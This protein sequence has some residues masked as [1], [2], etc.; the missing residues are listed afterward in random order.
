MKVAIGS[1]AGRTTAGTQN[2]TDASVT[3]DLVAAFFIGSNATA[4]GTTTAGA[5]ATFGCTDGTRNINYGYGSQDNTALASIVTGMVGS[6]TACLQRCGANGNFTV[7]ASLSAV[8]SNG[9]T[10]NYTTVDGVAYKFDYMLISGTDLEIQ[11]SS[12][13]FATTDTSKVVTHNCAAAPDAIMYFVC[14]GSTGTDS[15]FGAL[16][17]VMGMFDGTNAAG[18]GPCTV[19]GATTYQVSQHQAADGGHYVNGFDGGASDVAT[20]SVSAV[21]ATTFTLNRTASNS[22][23]AFVVCVSFRHKSGNAAFNAFQTT[24]PTATGNTTLLTGMAVKPQVLFTF[25]TRLTSTA[26]TGDSDLAGGFGFGMSCNNNGTTQQGAVATSIQNNVSTS[27]CKSYE[28]PSFGL[29]GLDHVGTLQR[30]AV[31]NSWDSGGVTLNWSAV[32]A[33]AEEVTG[34]AFGLLASAAAV[35]TPYTQTQFFVTETVN[36]Q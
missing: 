27:V 7:Q 30:S 32:D 1:F 33:S 22:Q 10:L 3:S 11:C 16:R 12:T 24:M 13:Q 23:A 34:L 4:D 25:P 2:V 5:T 20:F 36:Q 9:L 28:S 19:K 21:G 8:L 6:S 14:T 26:L 17:T 18:T 29:L 35:Y 15:F 31:V